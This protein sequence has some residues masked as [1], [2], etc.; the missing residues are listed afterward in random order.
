MWYWFMRDFHP[1]VSQYLY[2]RSSGLPYG[3][4]RRHDR[5]VIARPDRSI[6]TRPLSA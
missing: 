3:I 4:K 5:R 1:A 6:T 2:S